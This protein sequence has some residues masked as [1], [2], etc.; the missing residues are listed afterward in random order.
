MENNSEIFYELAPIGYFD[1][2]ESA[3]IVK[4]NLTGAKFLEIPRNFL[5]GKRFSTFVSKNTQPLFY[6]N[7]QQAVISKVK[8]TCELELLKKDGSFFYSQIESVAMVNG[9][10]DRP[11][12]RLT[13]INIHEHRMT[14]YALRASEGKF[15]SLL[16]ATKEWLWIIDVTGRFIYSNPAVMGL[17]NYAS[18]EIL[19]RNRLT[20]I[21]KDDR[22]AAAKIFTSAIR[23]KRGWA[24]AYFR[25]H[26]KAGTYHYLE[27]NAVPFFDA[28]GKVLGFQG[29][30]RDIMPRNQ[31]EHQTFQQQKALNAISKRNSLIELTS[32]LAHELV[33][34]ITA[35]NNYITGSI[36]RLNPSNYVEVITALKN[37]AKEIK[38]VEQIICRMRDFATYGKL[39]FGKCDINEL[40]SESIYLIHQEF[41]ETK[42][43]I[44]FDIKSS[45]PFIIADKLQL[46]QVVI[47]LLRNAI[48][49][50]M[51][52]QISDPMIHIRCENFSN[53]HIF[54]SV[55][56]NGVG[57]T[58]DNNIDKIFEAFFTT[59]LKGLGMGLAIS[60]TI[61]EA[62]QGSLTAYR[63]PLNRGMCFKLTLP[64]KPDDREQE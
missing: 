58:L 17:L 7:I 51:D 9:L 53:Q 63:S 2:D 1:L 41:T 54:V 55:S 46:E 15:R 57:F 42:V 32:T 60:K 10:K 29:A 6:M 3:R 45:K 25:W 64:V 39:C 24:G 50:F 34:P 36:P 28:K 13:V 59:K 61:V 31:T 14:E 37:A 38:R 11:H 56:D 26:S 16:E 21:H 47:N 5:F 12:L 49:A 20:L 44:I 62:H 19:N 22:I 43:K 4:V 48:E 27:S 33:Q 40:V 52:N 23:E 30:I 8:Q 35:V 18:D